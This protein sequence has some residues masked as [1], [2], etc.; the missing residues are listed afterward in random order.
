M[1][2]D[3]PLG[4]FTPPEPK[5]KPTAKAPAP[6]VGEWT[7]S[8]GH[9]VVQAA[10]HEGRDI[11]DLLRDWQDWEREEGPPEGETRMARPWLDEET[12]KWR[13]LVVGTGVQPGEVVRVFT[14]RGKTWETT[15]KEVLETTD[16]NDTICAEVPRKRGLRR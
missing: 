2:L 14:S 10:Q 1:N 16:Y 6:R 11:I 8:R 9:T 15:V 4:D 5:T 13:V 7:N 3:D 12:D